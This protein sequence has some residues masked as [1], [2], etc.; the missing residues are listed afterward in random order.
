MAR[1]IKAASDNF[2]SD[3]AGIMLFREI[4]LRFWAG[5]FLPWIGK[6]HGSNTASKATSAHGFDR[7]FTL[8]SVN[9][10]IDTDLE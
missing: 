6:F 8:L 4:D 3:E 9:T 10:G 2:R 1:A 7:A 5:V